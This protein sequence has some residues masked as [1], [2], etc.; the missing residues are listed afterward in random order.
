MVAYSGTFG[1]LMAAALLTFAAGEAAAQQGVV[2]GRVTTRDGGEPVSNAQV[3]VHAGTGGQ[4]T[5]RRS[6]E[7]GTF[8]VSVSPGTYSV[9]VQRIGFS[10]HTERGVVVVSGGTT[11]VNVA[12]DAQ[13]HVL[14]KVA[15]IGTPT[16]TT[17]GGG[18]ATT[19]EV[20]RE[21]LEERPVLSLGAHLSNMNGID[22]PPLGKQAGAPVAR[23]FNNVFSGAILM[24]NDYRYAGVPS[25]RVNTPYLIP[26][27][28]EDVASMQVLLGPASALYGPNATSGV[29]HIISKSPFES[30]GTTVSAGVGEHS[31]F[32]VAARH[33][34][35]PTPRFAYKISAQ[36]LRARDWEY[37]DPAETIP[38]DFDIER[39][40]GE[41]RTDLQ[42]SPNSS[43]ILQA[44]R[45]QAGKA[46]EMTG[47]GTAQA[48]DW[49]YTYYQARYAVNRLF[50]QTFL[51]QSDTKDTYLLRSGQRII[52]KS[53]LIAAQARH[54]FALGSRQNFSYGADFQFTEP[55][56][57]GTI[58][59]RNEENDEIT[60]Y[61]AFLH[62][63]T[64]LSRKLNLILAGRADKHSLLDDPEFSPR[65]SLVFK[66][67]QGQTV[68]LTFNSAFSTPTPNNLF[69]DL[70]AQ[71][72]N[73]Q[74]PYFIR[75]LG[76]PRSGFQF[77][78]DCTGGK[79]GLCMRS[80]FA[81][82]PGA[83][84][85]PFMPTDVTL[86]WPVV[87]GMLVAR[88]IDTTGL[89]TPTSAQIPTRLRIVTAPTDT[90]TPAQV[91][92]VDPLRPNL[93]STYEAGY[94]G[95]VAGRVRL[96]AD[97][98][99]ETRRDFTGPLIIETPNAFFDAPALVG[100][101]VSRG[102]TVAQ[103]TAIAQ[104]IGPIPFGTVTPDHAL[105]Q[106]AD[107]MLTYRNFGRLERWGA[108]LGFEALLA[109]AEATTQ[110]TLTGSYSWV[111][112]DLYPRDEVGGV[113]DVTLN[114][115]RK[116][117]KLGIR[118]GQERRGLSVDLRGRWSDGFPMN[119]GVFVGPVDSYTVVDAT[120][121]YRFP[122]AKSMI[123]SVDATNLL[124]RRYRAF[125]GAPEIG[126]FVMTQ[127]QVT[128]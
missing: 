84:V 43:L 105:T 96:V 40:S 39:W 59:G 7:Q 109:P 74:L 92:D 112:K 24:M 87:K 10:P 90:L 122:F 102:R 9:L 70:I 15:T 107:L 22:L 3:S 120:V 8:R 79:G 103:A 1:M 124:D 88:G 98:Y 110:W 47:I 116:K 73:P 117:A 119:S 75:T 123:L 108:D 2:T 55:R 106:N 125:V 46:L 115:P 77:R 83:A 52:D 31:T 49:S 93:V 14:E 45:A 11:E 18:T 44:G 85:V 35:A 121:A 65:V 118:V 33:A 61:G 128:F 19:D 82:P 53:R 72:L 41:I 111:N 62:S 13:G 28:N 114:A 127:L 97:V 95:L 91:R 113:S 86:L 54:G 81:A 12:L 48:K 50:V 100:Y 57:N 16:P 36:L 4:V 71:R 6:D 29:V 58:N 126:R 67:V 78:R 51:N 5:Q 26:T 30:E 99:H 25:L 32:R 42:P 104:V 21:Q 37:Q 60:E 69:L 68:R 23:G 34:L 76:V 27:T 80:P 64:E 38:R 20:R 101:L 63:E 56:T 66:P 89:G 94:E 17:E